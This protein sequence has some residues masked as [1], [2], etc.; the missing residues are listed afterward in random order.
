MGER[1]WIK[2]DA[3]ELDV[4]AVEETLFALLV[5][6]LL[7]VVV[8]KELEDEAAAEME[9]F[10][11]PEI[12]AEVDK[13]GAEDGDAA[14]LTKATPLFKDGKR[15]L[16]DFAF[17]QSCATPSHYKLINYPHSLTHSCLIM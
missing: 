14:D 2:C 11:P 7:M 5:K 8:L 3:E 4:A 10:P 17:F 1:G 16:L 6:E 12:E 9:L 15:L 13:R